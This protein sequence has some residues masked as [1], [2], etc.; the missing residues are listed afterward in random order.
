MMKL[1][2]GWTW[3]S[4]LVMVNSKIDK[5]RI[6]EGVGTGIDDSAS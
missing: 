4:L 3:W 5:R 1:S 2:P 6:K